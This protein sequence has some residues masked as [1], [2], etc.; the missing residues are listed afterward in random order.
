MHNIMYI[1]YIIKKWVKLAWVLLHLVTEVYF[2]AY[3][4][5]KY[6]MQKCYVFL[7]YVIATFT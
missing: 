5:N 1:I 6:C 3:T 4:F 7:H 2:D